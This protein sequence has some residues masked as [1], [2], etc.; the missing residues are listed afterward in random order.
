MA[1]RNLPLGR[2]QRSTLASFVM[3]LAAATPSWAQEAAKVARADGAETPLRVYRP[4]SEG[5]QGCAPLALISPGAGGTENGYAYLA[6]GLRD[7]G[8]LAIV[9]GHKESG[10]GKLI[11]EVSS[12]GVHGGLVEMVTDPVLH[13]DRLMDVAAALGWAEKQCRR[14]FKVLLGHS[15]GTDT[16]MFEAGAE[17]KL[18]VHG[19]D[20]FDAYVTISPSGPGSI[21]PEHAWSKIHKPLFVLTGTEDKGLEGPWEWRTRPY[22]DLPPGCKWL[23]V[24]D[25]ATHLNFAGIGFARKTKQLT[26]DSVGAFLDG[27]RKGNCSAPPTEEGM[28]LKSK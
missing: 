18:G 14:P 23:G 2:L 24:T 8:W 9:M 28:Q 11:G 13:R 7:R 26:L 15:M 6:E 22:D 4:A 17:N 1:R 16:V 19:E 3:V 12:S 25:G 21:F 10:P 5:K 27:A 20:R